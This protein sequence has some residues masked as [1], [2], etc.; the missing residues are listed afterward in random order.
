VEALHEIVQE[1]EFV[2]KKLEVVASDGVK[3]DPDSYSCVTWELELLDE[4]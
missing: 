2:F 4:E 1:F 3:G